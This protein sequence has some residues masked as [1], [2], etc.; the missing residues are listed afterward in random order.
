MGEGGDLGLDAL[1]VA[2]MGDP[3]LKL[4]IIGVSSGDGVKVPQ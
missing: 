2:Q 1:M 4:E 3:P